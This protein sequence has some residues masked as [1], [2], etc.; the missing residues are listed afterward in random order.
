MKM[1]YFDAVI[2]I[3]SLSLDLYFLSAGKRVLGEELFVIFSLRMWRF[4]RIISSESIGLA[5]FEANFLAFQ[6]W[7]KAFD[8]A[9]RN[10]NV[11]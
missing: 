5:F 1:E 2:V 3:V 10:T 7:P 11:T 8:T 4:V 9:K 6:A